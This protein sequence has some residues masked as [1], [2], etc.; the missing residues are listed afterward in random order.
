MKTNKTLQIH[1]YSLYVTL[2]GL[3]AFSHFYLSNQALLVLTESMTLMVSTTNILF[4]LAIPIVFKLFSIMMNK[5]TAGV[6][7]YAKWALVQMYLVTFPAVTSVVLYGLMADKSALYCYLIAFI[8]LIF[9]KPTQQKWDY[10]QQKEL[11]NNSPTE[12][13]HE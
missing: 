8:A 4:L 2:L 5:P 12:L 11:S 3:L 13:S 6:Q 10:Y 7:D 9:C 1:Y